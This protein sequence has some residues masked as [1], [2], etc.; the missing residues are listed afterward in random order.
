MPLSHNCL[1]IKIDQTRGF[2]TL[3]AYSILGGGELETR[4]C[5]G[6]IPDIL[7]LLVW[8]GDEMGV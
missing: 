5:Q 6:P 2:S 8:T 4:A 7:I 3:T 1:S